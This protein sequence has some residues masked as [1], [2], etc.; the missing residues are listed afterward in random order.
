MTTDPFQ[1]DS[2]QD[3]EK[4][5][6]GTTV[7]NLL[8]ALMAGCIFLPQGNQLAQRLLPLYKLLPTPSGIQ[9]FAPPVK[10]SSKPSAKPQAGVELQEGKSISNAQLAQSIVDYAK[11]RGW[12]LREGPNRYNIFYVQGMD[13]DNSLNKSRYNAFDDL[14]I[15]LVIEGGVPRI[16]AK[17]IATTKPG[18]YYHKYPMNKKGVSYIKPGQYR[19]WIM[20]YHRS[21]L[22][23]AL[24]QLGGPVTV[25]RDNKRPDTGFFGINQ[26][27]VL[28]RNVSRDT[29]DRA[30][31]GC[32]VV[33]TWAH[34][35]QFVA[36]MRKDADFQRDNSYRFYTGI[37][38]GRQ[39]RLR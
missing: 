24:V 4:L 9:N 34:Q 21:F 10:P 20:G 17:W 3:E 11:S 28:N 15:L 2:Q 35:Q 36:Y 29:V 39:L 18:D 32:L 1:S 25:L 14:R 5:R 13:P 26:H 8:I 12:V 23:P 37:I 7:L 30:S 19:A 31:A 16:V 38:P 33:P 22:H 6:R 27:G